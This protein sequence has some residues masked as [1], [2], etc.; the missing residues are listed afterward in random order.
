M[1]RV[2]WWSV[3]WMTVYIVSGW[4]LFWLIGW[5]LERATGAVGF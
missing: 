1:K 4:L 3:G 2:D 5:V